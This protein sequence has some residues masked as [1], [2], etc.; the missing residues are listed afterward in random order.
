MKKV[1]LLLCF[2]VL[3]DMVANAQLSITQNVGA[4]ATLFAHT[5]KMRAYTN[6]MNVVYSKD[7]NRQNIFYFVED[8]NSNVPYC[9]LSNY[10]DVADFAILDSM[11]YF[12]GSVKNQNNE[13]EAVIGYFNIQSVLLSN[14]VIFLTPQNVKYSLINGIHQDKV[15]SIDRI[16]AYRD[17][18]DVPIIAGIGKMYY[19][20][21]PYQ[22]M[23]PQTGSMVLKDPDEYYLD[24]LMFYTVQEHNVV[25]NSYDVSLHDSTPNYAP[26]NDVQMFYVPTDTVKSHY[27][28]KFADIVMTDNNINLISIDYSDTIAAL[29][30]NSRSMNISIFDK[31]TLQQRNYKVSLPFE[32]HQEYGFAATQMDSNNF[33]ISAVKFDDNTQIAT[34]CVMEFL[35]NQSGDLLKGNVSLFDNQYGK[36][37]SLDCEYLQKNHQIIVLKSAIINNEEREL[38]Y[39][40][41]TG[42]QLTFPYMSKM[43]LVNNVMDNMTIHW[44]DLMYLEG[45]S[46]SVV[47]S[48]MSRLMLHERSYLAPDSSANGCY[49]TIKLTVYKSSMSIGTTSSLGQCTFPNLTPSVVD[50]SLFIFYS[51]TDVYHAI[52]QQNPLPQL[53][54]TGL[55][56]ECSN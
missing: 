29:H 43:Y 54:Q 3:F 5:Q 33:A 40:L 35:V 42:S 10:F 49:Q 55:V 13:D 17:N 8:G 28:N 41:S 36:A 56:S 14:Q 46:Y 12:A 21:P 24:F 52:L 4:N 31:N 51:S 16:E 18:K 19:G 7:A 15:F 44:N 45:T 23:S 26:A 37:S 39:H 2:A 47:G 27:Y 50:G 30:G 20:K 38:L 9:I 53:Y 48:K 11:L 6:Q 25:T 22:Q 32:I 1:C 34:G